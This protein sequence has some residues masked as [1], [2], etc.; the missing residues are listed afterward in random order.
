M[1]GM[2]S[3]WYMNITLA[4]T[5]TLGKGKTAIQKD[6]WPAGPRAAAALPPRVGLPLCPQCSPARSRRTHRRG[7]PT[8]D[9]SSDAV[10][11]F[12]RL[13]PG[14][15]VL[16]PSPFCPTLSACSHF[17]RASSNSSMPEYGQGKTVRTQEGRAVG[18]I[19]CHSKRPQENEEVGGPKGN[20]QDPVG[21]A[22]C[23]PA[24]RPDG[25]WKLSTVQA[26]LETTE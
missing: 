1:P 20:G 11:G 7:P 25:F 3:T 14:V 15:G 17:C 10:S 24:L 5:H 2:C 9:S 18:P 23:R 19:L 21:W 13:S 4:W 8:S 6:K 22:A 16:P 12:R 26:W